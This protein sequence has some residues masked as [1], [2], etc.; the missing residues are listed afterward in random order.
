MPLL[1][2][3]EASCC[4]LVA[5]TVLLGLGWP[6]PAGGALPSF[7]NLAGEGLM[8]LGHVEWYSRER[9]LFRVKFFAFIS[10]QEGSSR[11]SR[12]IKSWSVSLEGTAQH[13]ALG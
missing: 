12:T 8:G 3:C 6:G 10:N 7:V 13:P 1:R 5:L 4:W 11:F 2:F 9:F